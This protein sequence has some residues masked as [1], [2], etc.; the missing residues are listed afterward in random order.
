MCS[1]DLLCGNGRNG[2]GTGIGLSR[3]LKTPRLGLVGNNNVAQVHA[4]VQAKISDYGHNSLGIIICVYPL[5]VREF[6]T[7]AELGFLEHKERIAPIEWFMIQQF[8]VWVTVGN[9]PLGNSRQQLRPVRS[10]QIDEAPID[11]ASQQSCLGTK[12]R[13]I[14]VNLPEIG[15]GFPFICFSVRLGF[16]VVQSNRLLYFTLNQMLQVL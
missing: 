15:R 5:A 10:A 12:F 2:S 1:S 9:K 4:T 14:E 13:L 16:C 8:K 7:S 11:H 3:P 6:F